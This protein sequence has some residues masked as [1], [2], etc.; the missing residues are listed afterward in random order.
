M[1]PLSFSKRIKVKSGHFSLGYQIK[2][3][4]FDRQADFGDQREAVW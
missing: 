3:V 1:K 4:H 2:Q